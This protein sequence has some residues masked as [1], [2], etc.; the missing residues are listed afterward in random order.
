M[1]DSEYKNF[2]EGK[3]HTEVTF[4]YNTYLCSIPLDFSSVPVHWHEEMELIVVKK[5]VES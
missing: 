1:R 4:P 5:G 3:K 2:R